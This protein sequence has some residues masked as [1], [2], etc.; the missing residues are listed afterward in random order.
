MPVEQTQC[1][2]F[3][4][5][6][7]FILLCIGVPRCPSVSINTLLSTVWLRFYL[8]FVSGRHFVAKP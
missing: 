8:Y 1:N 5:T 2:S 4:Q 7:G 3:K 6:K